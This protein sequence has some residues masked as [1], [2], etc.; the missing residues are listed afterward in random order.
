MHDG[1][2]ATLEEVVE[3]EIYYRGK[4]LGRPVVLGLAERADLLAF[5]KAL[6]EAPTEQQP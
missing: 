4:T 2:I 1:S 6:T 3:R 5:L